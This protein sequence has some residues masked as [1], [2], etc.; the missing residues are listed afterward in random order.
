MN[1]IEQDDEDEEIYFNQF[2]NQAVNWQQET[3]EHSLNS[4]TNSTGKEKELS[5]DEE[6]SNQNKTDQEEDESS[7]LS[8]NSS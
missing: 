6:N 2:N 5:D 8:K 3:I 4:N 1:E 7:L